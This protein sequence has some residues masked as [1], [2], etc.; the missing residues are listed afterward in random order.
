MNSTD[1]FIEFIEAYNYVKKILGK[2]STSQYYQS[3]KRTEEESG[4][5]FKYGLRKKYV[6]TLYIWRMRRSRKY[7][8]GWWIDNEHEDLFFEK[9]KQFISWK[10]KVRPNLKRSN[11]LKAK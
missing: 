6:G 9:K 7:F 3:V 11:I 1:V 2:S 5:K 4:L 8:I 10:K